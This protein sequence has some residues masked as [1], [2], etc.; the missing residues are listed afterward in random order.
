MK[1]DEREEHILLQSQR[2][3][4]PT[5]YMTPIRVHPSTHPFIIA[6]QQKNEHETTQSDYAPVRRCQTKCGLASHSDAMRGW[7]KVG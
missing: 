5:V 4:A 3:H 7:A 2:H 1:H 6:I